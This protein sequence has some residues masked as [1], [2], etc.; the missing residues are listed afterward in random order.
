ME[1]ER[2]TAAQ[3]RDGNSDA[4]STMMERDISLDSDA[5]ETLTDSEFEEI[6]GK[7]NTNEEGL[8]VELL[9]KAMLEAFDENPMGVLQYGPMT[10][11]PKLVEWIRKRMVSA[12]NAPDEGY[13]PLELVGSGKGLGLIART[14][15]G[16]GDRAFCDE[17]TFPNGFNSMKNIGAEAVGIP[18]DDQGMIP[19]ALEKEAS[20]GKGKYVYLIPNFQNPTGITI[21]LQRRKDLL[22]VARKYDLIIY[23]D[24]PYGDIRFEGEEVPTL[25]SLDPDG[26]VIYA[27]SFS[28]TL[29][30]GIRSGYLYGKKEVIEK[31]SLVKSAD[32][33][34]CRF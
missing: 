7:E 4:A 18:M 5:E 15:L 13:M 21:P 17:F 8:A 25:I 9:R 12:K 23:E 2:N 14:L 20:K 30:A 1:E 19:E 6:L 26:R 27:G 11:D 24:D 32:K 29:S 34:F 3:V 33:I 16:E 22:E 10:G 28:K 31:I